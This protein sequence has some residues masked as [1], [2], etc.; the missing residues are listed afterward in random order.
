MNKV[1]RIIE[2]Y[3]TRKQLKKLSEEVYELQESILDLSEFIA[4][5]ISEKNKVNHSN[6]KIFFKRHVE[7]EIADVMVLLEEFK[8][9]FDLNY[10]N[11]LKIMKYK[12]DRQ[13]K[14]IDGEVNNETM[15]YIR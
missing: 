15:D 14:R 9:Y 7:E 4:N 2:Y 10:S 3:Q 12:V 8:I 1:K 5:D 11:I 13:N 6:A